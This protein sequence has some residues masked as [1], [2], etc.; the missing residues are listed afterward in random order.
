MTIEVTL[1]QAKMFYQGHKINYKRK[2]IDKTNFL[3]NI[4]ALPK[5]LLKNA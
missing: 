2:N 4:F 1:G 5:T 3:T